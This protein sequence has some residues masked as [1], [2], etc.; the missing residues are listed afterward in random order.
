MAAEILAKTEK[1]KKGWHSRAMA[2]IISPVGRHGG[3]IA[4]ELGFDF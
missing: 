4:G 2:A 3:T 1:G